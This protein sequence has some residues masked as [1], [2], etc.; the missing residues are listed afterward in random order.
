[1]FHFLLELPQNYLRASKYKTLIKKLNLFCWL[2]AYAA[3]KVV[4]IFY[5]ISNII[6]LLTSFYLPVEYD[7]RTRKI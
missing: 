3:A 5:L 2:F 6:S 7:E 1:M 4:D